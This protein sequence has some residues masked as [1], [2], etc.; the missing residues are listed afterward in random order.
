MEEINMSF[1]VPE[2]RKIRVIL[3]CDTKNEVD[4]QYAIVHALLTPRFKI[5][6]LIGAHFTKKRFADSMERSY[7]ENCKLVEMLGMSDSIDVLRGSSEPIKSR[8]EYEYSPGAQRIVE[9]ALKEEDSPLFVAFTGAITDLACAY[10]EHPEIAGRL[11]AIWIGGGRYPQGNREYNLCNDILAANIVFE[12]NIELWQ[13]PMNVYSKMTVSL[14]ELEMN[15]APYGEIGKYLYEEL[16][17]F[18]MNKLDRKEWPYGEVWS[19]GDSPSIGLLL[20]PMEYAC[21]YREAPHVNAD[22]SYS[23]T[24]KNRKIRVYDDINTRFIFGDFYAK[25]KKFTL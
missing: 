8:T 14:T 2:L 25:L 12:S 19:L 3:D 18:N 10:L 9:E 6:G 13:V 21:Q 16:I 4:D 7:Q 24:G 20:D 22:A 1:I 11:T 5:K 23:F 15:V 17:T